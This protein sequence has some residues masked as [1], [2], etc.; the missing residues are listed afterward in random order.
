MVGE[1][2][3][4]ETAAIAVQSALTGHLVFTTVTQQPS[5]TFS[6]LP[7]HEGRSLQLRLGAQLRPGSGCAENLRIM[8]HESRIR[9]VHHRVGLDRRSTA[10]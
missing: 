1:I 4:E 3:D 2:R 10:A 9:I 8:R 5:S 7:E 6:P